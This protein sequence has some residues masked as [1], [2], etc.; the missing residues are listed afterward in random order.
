MLQHQPFTWT[1]L[2]LTIAR[3]RLVAEAF[4]QMWSIRV[5]EDAR[6]VSRLETAGARHAA[7]GVGRPVRPVTSDC[8]DMLCCFKIIIF[9]ELL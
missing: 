3:F 2:C 5:I 7:V 9:I 4:R 6:A 1:S 8:K